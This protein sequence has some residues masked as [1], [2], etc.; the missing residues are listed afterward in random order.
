MQNDLAVRRHEIRAGGR[1]TDPEIDETSIWNL[2]GRPPS[3]LI[4][5]EFF[6]RL[7]PG[8]SFQC[9]NGAP[10]WFEFGAHH[11]GK[12]LILKYCRFARRNL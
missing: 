3:N 6:D 10:D 12:C 4:S 5:R 11:N 8:F 7:V 2:I 1:Q 9:H